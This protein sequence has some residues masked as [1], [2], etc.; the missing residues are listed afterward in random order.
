MTK[1]IIQAIKCRTVFD[2]RGVETLEVDVLTPGGGGRAAAPFGAPGSRGEFEAP[3]Y[4]PG[5]VRA[6]LK[7]VVDELV[8]R[9]IGQD[10]A[11]W[12][13]IDALIR[14]VDGRPNFSRLGGNSATVFSVAGAKA[15]AAAL[16]RPLFE[17]LN[18]EGGY[19]LPFPLGNIIGGG[20]HSLGPAPDM[21]EHLVAPV[22]A[23]DIR[24]AIEINL[25]V[26]E[27][28]GKILARRDPG[29]VGGTDDE[30]AWVADLNDMEAFEVLE[31]AAAKVSAETRVEIRLGFDLAAD[32]LWDPEKKVYQYFREGVSRSPAEQLDYLEDLARRFKFVYLE[33]GFHSNDYRAFAGLNERV[34]RCG[35]VCADD[36]Y[37]SDPERTKAGLSHKS[38]R[39]MIIKTNQI[40]T[41]SGALS[42]ARL[43]RA[44]GL[45]VVISHRSGE[46]PDDSIAHQAVAWGGLMI[47]T[48]VKGG[49]RLAKLN[50]LIRLK[51]RRPELE[52]AAWPALEDYR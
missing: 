21:Q 12:P 17:L 49:E 11:D 46:T 41:L 33:D 16:G 34:G 40:G 24:E 4:A 48:G 25:K 5:G 8:P 28:A 29:F 32:R 23:G 10:A 35:L 52:M 1:T 39:A 43:A 50:E 42:T 3:D 37:A 14:E 13:K 15:A 19:S 51:E 44:H 36:L 22:G 30:N 6:A 45:A 7:L 38:A 9:L 20:A 31:E 2:S 26:H 18:P 27:A 47:K